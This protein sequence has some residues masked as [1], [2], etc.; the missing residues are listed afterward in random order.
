MFS[1]SV[2]P[3]PS[4]YSGVPCAGYGVSAAGFPGNAGQVE[5]TELLAHALS[6]STPWP[7]GMHASN[8]PAAVATIQARQLLT[9]SQVDDREGV[10][11]RRIQQHQRQVVGRGDLVLP[12]LHISAPRWSSTGPQLGLWGCS[13]WWHACA[14][15]AAAEALHGHWLPNVC[16]VLL[17]GSKSQEGWHLGWMEISFTLRRW[18]LPC[19]SAG[20]D[21]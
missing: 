5:A 21:V 15:A 6:C 13:S 1:W 2:L 12:S 17:T 18:N 10:R 14:A 9:A 4:T 7:D 20:K 8:K 3:Q 19:I 16:G 11:Q